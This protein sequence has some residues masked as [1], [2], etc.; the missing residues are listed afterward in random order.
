M[1][2]ASTTLSLAALELLV[3]ADERLLSTAPL[4]SCRASWPGDLGVENAPDAT[5]VKGWRESPAPG[6]LAQ[7]G[8][9]WVSES[10]SAILLVRSA[11]IP[12]EMNVL[13]NP[14]HP[15]AA[16]IVYDAPEPFAYDARLT[17]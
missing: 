4:V 10:R 8:D 11:L 14:A 3:H 5:Y 12:V 9:R 17:P 2:Y 1:A 16:R 15:D 7:F 13:V 6:A